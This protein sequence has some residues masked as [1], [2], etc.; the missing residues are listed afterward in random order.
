MESKALDKSIMTVPV[1]LRH[2][3]QTSSHPHTSTAHFVYNGSSE[4]RLCCVQEFVG[5]QELN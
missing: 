4:A 3:G 1:T 2:H 5:L